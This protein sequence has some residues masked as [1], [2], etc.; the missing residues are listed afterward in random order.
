[1]TGQD[2]PARAES[3]RGEP[4]RPE[5]APPGL[6]VLA[7]DDELPA[8]EEVAWLLRADPRVGVVLTANGPAEGLRVLESQR[9][10][11]VFLDLR[12][13]G[14][15]GLDLARVLGRFSMP[16][17]VVFVTAHD[18]AAVQAFD[19]GA[20]DY[21]LK[22]VRRE[23]LAEAVRR[24]EESVRSPGAGPTGPRADETIAVELAGRTRFVNRRDVLRAEAAGDYARLHTAEGSH[25]V[26]VPLA[27]LEERW[28]PAGF[29]RVHRSHLVAVHHV[30]ELRSEP[31]RVVVLVGGEEIVVSRRHTRLLKE[32]LVGESRMG[33]GP[34][35]SASATAGGP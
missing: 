7:V 21:V 20:V 30:T 32:R 18:D 33:G 12:M 10:D 24:V 14:L 22:P 5:A 29:V 35:S 2:A 4:A 16:P 15:S 28:G 6:A 9:L 17:A 11:A 13:P 27:T 1:V 8:L 25:L 26:R 31:G 19:V 34:R 3:A 23:R